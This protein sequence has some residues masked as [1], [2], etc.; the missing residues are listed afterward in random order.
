MAC[1][2]PNRIFVI[3]KNPKTGKKKI[4]FCS[5][6]VRAVGV[7]D[8]GSVDRF[9]EDPEK[10]K[11]PFTYRSRLYKFVV[12]DYIDVPC[13]KCLGCRLAY[14]KQWTSRIMLELPYHDH[15]WFVT[16]TYDDEH[17]PINEFTDPV[18]SEVGEST[19]LVKRHVQLFMKKLRNAYP[20][21]HLMYFFAGEYGDRS[22]RPHY[23]AIIFDLPLDDLVFYKTSPNGDIYFNSPKLEKIWSHGF[24][25]VANVTYASAAYTARYIMKK[26]NVSDENSIYA[27]KNIEPEFC[28]MSQKP[29]IGRRYFEDHPDVY[30]LDY[31]SLAGGYRAS[32]PKYFDYLLEKVDA[33]RLQAIKE[34]R[35]FFAQHLANIKESMHT[36]DRESHFDVIHE[37]LVSRSKHLAK[38]L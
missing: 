11:V 13:G 18:T 38:D 9:Y 14:S 3:G 16:L 5:R 26:Q 28:L 19:T 35:K 36:Y 24:V 4:V 12:S 22:R 30:D 25:V 27:R 34:E 8:D 10:D 29:S 6:F 32:I 20:D 31:L 21:N 17:L 33:E 15:S 37:N 1:S 7:K 2:N 23:H